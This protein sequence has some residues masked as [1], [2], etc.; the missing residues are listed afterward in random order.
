MQGINKIYSNEIGISF[1]WKN[2]SPSDAYKIQLIFRDIG[3]LLTIEELRF[4]ANSC[5]L[6]YTS[7]TCAD[8]KLGNDCR[9][10]LLKTPSDKIDIAVSINELDQIMNLLDHTIL[11]A[12]VDFRINISFN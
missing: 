7:H 10:L 6:T 1:Y 3:F 5:Q 9:N 4:F 8:C 12:E 2:P 11:K